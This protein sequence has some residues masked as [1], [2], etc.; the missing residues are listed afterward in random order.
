MAY[1]LNVWN[2]HDYVARMRNR[3]NAP[4]SWKDVLNVKYSNNRTIVNGYMSVEPSVQ[5]IANRGDQYTYQDYT[6]AQ[7]TLTISTYKNI[8]MLIDEADRSQQTYVDQMKIAEFQAK[9]IHEA[10]ETDYLSK[11]ASWS[12]FGAN[13]LAGTGSGDTTAITVSATNIDDI[14]RAVKRK[15]Y[16]NNLVDMAV[17]NGICIVWRATDFELLE[18]YAAANGFTEADLALKNGIPVQ[19]G[20]YYGGITHYLSNSHAAGHVF[21]GVKG[22]GEIGILSGTYGQAKFIEDPN[23]ISGLGIVSRVDYGFNWPTPYVQAF[24]DVN[25]A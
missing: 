20:F 4:T 11:H 7:D 19:K 13:D 5:T 25:V 15:L 1:S 18:G 16:A 21:A 8:P 24:Q 23:L 2:K 6:L 14:M 22:V 10:I 9:K 12:N 3:L 17:E